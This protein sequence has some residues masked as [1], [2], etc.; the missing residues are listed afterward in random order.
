MLAAMEEVCRVFAYESIVGR[1]LIGLQH[2]LDQIADQNIKVPYRPIPFAQRV[3]F[4]LFAQTIEPSVRVLVPTTQTPYVEFQDLSLP[5]SPIEE[6]G[7]YH[8]LRPFL[9]NYRARSL[10]YALAINVSQSYPPAIICSL[11]CSVRDSF[12]LA[13]VQL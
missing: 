7:A 9:L 6:N 3:P 12:A 11:A 5:H 2:S 8:L 13:F 10:R 1:C 4:P